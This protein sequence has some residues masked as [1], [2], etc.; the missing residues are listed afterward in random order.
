MNYDY[1]ILTEYFPESVIEEFKVS[2][3]DPRLCLLNAEFL[4]GDKAIS[5]LL[6]EV[7]IHNNN[8]TLKK[9]YRDTYASIVEHGGTSYTGIDIE[10]GGVAGCTSFKPLQPRLD[11]E[12]KSIKY[13]HPA[14][15]PC[16]AFLPIIDGETWQAISARVGVD[17][18]PDLVTRQ[19]QLA[20]I[21]SDEWRAEC[22]RL[23]LAFLQWIR[24]KDQ[25]FKNQKPEKHRRT[26]RPPR[27]DTRME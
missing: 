21:G 20:D 14:K 25:E 22:Q 8:G 12:G 17:L 15:K 27:H 18:P 9:G 24:E 7:K 1:S 3:I 6:G 19:W 11:K 16:K 10:R 13:E 26:S 2:A 23:S 5:E 4:N